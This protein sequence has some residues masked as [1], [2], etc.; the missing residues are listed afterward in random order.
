MDVPY[1]NQHTMLGNHRPANEMPF[2]CFRCCI[3]KKEERKAEGG[4]GGLATGKR[5]PLKP[6]QF[7]WCFFGMCSCFFMI[8]GGG[9]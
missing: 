9:G 2:K 4:G 8:W 6:I 1:Y 3:A 5:A 7:L